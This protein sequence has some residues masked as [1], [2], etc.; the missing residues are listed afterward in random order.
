MVEQQIKH[1]MI[2][3]KKFEYN[4]EALRG[5]AAFT[6]LLMHLS[7]YSFELNGTAEASGI[8]FPYQFPGHFAVLLFF[9]LSGYVIGL[10]TRQPLTWATTGAYLKK[11]FLRLY[12][13]Y[14]AGILFVLCFTHRHYS[15]TAISTNLAFLQGAAAPPLEEITV[16]WSLHYEVLFYLLFIPISVFALKPAHCFVFS[17][18][19][20]FFFQLVVPAPLLATYGYG[21]CFWRLGLWLAQTERVMPARPSRYTLLGLLFLMLAS[22]SLNIVRDVLHFQLHMDLM[23]RGPQPQVNSMIIPF[24]DF[25]YLPLALLVITSF[26]D[27]RLRYRSWL[28][29]F[30]L[31]VPVGGFLLQLYHARTQA[32][33]YQYFAYL[34]YLVSVVLLLLGSRRAPA[35]N[36]LPKFMVALGSISYGVYLIHVPLIMLMGRVSPFSGTATSWVVRALLVIGLSLVAGYLLEKVYQPFAVRQLKKTALFKSASSATLATTKQTFMEEA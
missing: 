16:I 15:F 12:P 7:S 3:R 2:G 11:R 30:V 33:N 26:T 36:Q 13:I 31:A 21:F 4:L 6:V 24:S 8:F 14:V 10:T 22:N 32:V 29:A 23:R 28:M 25:S 18:L 27:K 17:L 5:F 1:S 20:A 34:F 19:W 9:M 35:D